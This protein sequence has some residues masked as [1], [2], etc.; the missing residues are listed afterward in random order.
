M[1]STKPNPVTTFYD[2][3]MGEREF[4]FACRGRPFTVL[5][6]PQFPTPAFTMIDHNLVRELRLTMTDLQCV[7]MRYGG[8]NLR[9]LGRIS[10]SVQCVIDG[11]PAG[12]VHL[13]AHVVTDIYQLFNTYAIAGVKMSQRLY[14]G[15]PSQHV[16]E[17]PT[18]PTK[19]KKKRKRR[20]NSE[21]DP[22]PSPKPLCQGI[23][24]QHQEYHGWDI[25]HGNAV[26][27]KLKHRWE[28]RKTGQITWKKPDSWNSEANTYFYP[29]SD[30]DHEDTS[31][32]YSDIYTNVSTV[33]YNTEPGN[34]V[35]LSVN[36][37][38]FSNNTTTPPD[39]STA[40]DWILPK[41]GPPDSLGP[42]RAKL[43]STP[44]LARRK[45]LFR[46]G[47]ST[48]PDLRHVPVPHGADW[49]D[50]GCLEEGQDH[51]PPECGY[52]L[53]FGNIT[54]CSARCPG[55]WCQHTRQMSG[56][57]YMS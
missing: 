53:R 11:V 29:T 27:G 9:I 20:T 47:Q 12:N 49:C 43:F 5:T 13:K 44:Q 57:D 42:A 1:A 41:P 8:Q 7:K 21:C 24:I 10:T 52:H 25:V 45:K 36:Q 30:D 37:D 6:A 40:G 18:E 3:R 48:P 2:G 35:N 17:K 22:P 46:S 50:G 34:A 4:V 33:R 39:H 15:G 31:D 51:L 38:R 26:T 19:P 56:R 23:W 54:S 14:G 55:G 32:E 28:N 16:P